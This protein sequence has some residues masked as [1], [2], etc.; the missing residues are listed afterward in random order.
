MKWY[1]CNIDRIPHLYHSGTMLGF[2]TVV[3]TVV[4]TVI[5][6]ATV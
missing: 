6:F 5:S 1:S 2:V 3:V 4:V